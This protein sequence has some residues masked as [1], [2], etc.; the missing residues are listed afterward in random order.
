MVTFIIDPVSLK[1]EQGF[2]LHLTVIYSSQIATTHQAYK[3]P[4]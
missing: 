1:N 3:I 2:Y 4:Y